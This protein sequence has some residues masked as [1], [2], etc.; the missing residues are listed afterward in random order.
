V[1]YLAAQHH[2]CCR[3]RA[4]PVIRTDVTAGHGG[5]R[6]RIVEVMKPELPPIAAPV[7]LSATHCRLALRVTP[8]GLHDVRR[9]VRGQLRAW[10]LAELTM[11]AAMCVTEL[12]SN[13][14]K[15]ARSPE[16]VLTFRRITDGI[17]IS[18]IDT[19]PAMPVVCEPDHRSESGRGLFLLSET[20]DEW[21]AAPVGAGKEVWFVLRAPE[22]AGPAEPGDRGEV[23]T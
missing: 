15:H 17:R 14:H 23:P 18:V 12:L 13:V 6:T 20:V 4:V 5:S 7:Q 9:T 10:D 21:G 19:E 8:R 1:L 3:T 22:P 16:C 2:Y 11:S